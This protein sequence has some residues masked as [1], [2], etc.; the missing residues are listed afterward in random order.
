VQLAGWNELRADLE[1]EHR[2]LIPL[3]AAVG[4]MADTVDDLAPVD[5]TVALTS[6]ADDLDD[7]LLRHEQ[8]EE[9]S[10]YPAL[11]AAIG[12][13]DPMA[14]MSGSHREIFHLLRLLR[15]NIVRLSDAGPDHEQM[16]DI[17]RVLYS[18]HAILGLHFAQEEELYAAVSDPHPESRPSPVPVPARP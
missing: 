1:I 18:L 5:A 13:Q 6:L 12:G 8:L 9:T 10:V 17:R 7:R 16:R 4:R 14:V 15:R 11:A 3:V 2:K